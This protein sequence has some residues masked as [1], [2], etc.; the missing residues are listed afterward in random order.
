MIVE[1]VPERA[2]WR[3]V[4]SV[5]DM[6]CEWAGGDTRARLLLGHDQTVDWSNAAAQDFL[7]RE[8]ALRLRN[9]LLKAA[10]AAADAALR[11]F[12]ATV[13]ATTS[14]CCLPSC[15]DGA[16]VVVTAVRLRAGD[17]PAIGLTLHHADAQFA[18][19]LVNLKDA[20]GVTEAELKVASFLMNGKTADETSILLG[21]S[22]DTVR[23]HIRSLYAKLEVRS[24]EEL[25][26]KLAPFAVLSSGSAAVRRPQERRTFDAAPA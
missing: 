3:L 18:L 25:F 7:Q 15:R 8:T 9:G 4:H 5:S 2:A 11:Q 10:G 20:F 17:A 24:R 22:L 26:Y 23:S 19:S 12:L 13:S 14:A 1:P 16:R 21:V 6:L